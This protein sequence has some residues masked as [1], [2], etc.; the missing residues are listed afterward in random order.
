[1]LKKLEEPLV[2]VV[3]PF[4]N[5][6][7]KLLKAVESVLKQSYLNYEI[8]LIDDYSNID[9]AKI[10]V[11]AESRNNIFLYENKKN[12]GPGYSR[13]YGVEKSRGEFIAFLDSDDEWMPNKLKNQINHMLINKIK[14]SHTSYKRFDQRIKKF[15]KIN[16]GKINCSFPLSVFSCKVATPTVIVSKKILK[17]HIFPINIRHMEDIILWLKVSKETKFVGVNFFDC[18]VNVDD[19]TSAFNKDNY[20]NGMKIIRSEFFSKN[21]LLFFLHFLYCKMRGL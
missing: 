1:M 17:K 6:L 18:I 16:S 15:K 9:T 5:E 19:D 20:K 4:Y 8:L 3:I 13:N 2:S 12:M 14:A 21:K 10:K 11:I 7:D